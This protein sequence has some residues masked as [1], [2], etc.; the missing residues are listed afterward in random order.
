[1]IPCLNPKNKEVTFDKRG[2]SYREKFFSR[3]LRGIVRSE[4]LRCHPFVLEFL[5]TDH[6]KQN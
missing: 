4:E 3:F 5:K 1:M 2:I 6:F